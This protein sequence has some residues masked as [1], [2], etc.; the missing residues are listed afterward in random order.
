MGGFNFGG[1]NK[2]QSDAYL[3]TLAQTVDETDGNRNDFIGKYPGNGE[4]VLVYGITLKGST[5]YKEILS[6]DF[7]CKTCLFHLN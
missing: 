3:N 7:D 6:E 5:T 2:L 4:N 1:S